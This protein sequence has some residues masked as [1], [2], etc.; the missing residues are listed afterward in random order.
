MN[1]GAYFAEIPVILV[2]KDLP[3]EEISFWTYTP[4]TVVKPGDTM[5]FVINAENMYAQDKDI[6]LTI[7][8]PDGWSVTTGNGTELYLP[9]G[10]TG[11]FYLWVYVPRETKC[12]QLHHQPDRDRPGRPVQ[13]AGA[14][15]PG[16]RPAD[17]RRH[18]QR[19][20]P[21]GRGIPPA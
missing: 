17:V 21:L 11:S 4:E 16:R 12:R 10:K 3:F 13:H 18:H 1:G 14:E 5:S 6:R 19:A 7:D 20:E 8:K 15:G 2:V 9:D